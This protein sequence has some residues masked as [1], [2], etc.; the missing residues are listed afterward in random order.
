MGADEPGE[1]VCLGELMQAFRAGSAEPG[2]IGSAATSGAGKTM[3]VHV[4]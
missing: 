3:A 4:D 2:A 1:I